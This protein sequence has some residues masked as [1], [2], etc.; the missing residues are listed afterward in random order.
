M[1]KIAK[2]TI[3]ISIQVMR[4]T[5]MISHL[6]ENSNK[7]HLSEWIGVWSTKHTSLKNPRIQESTGIDG[8]HVT[9]DSHGG[10]VGVQEQ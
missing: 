10:H 8:L 7:E 3:I 1:N 2:Y 6:W 4:I 5:E 9:S